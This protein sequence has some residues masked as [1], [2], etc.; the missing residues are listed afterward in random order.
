MKRSFRHTTDQDIVRLVL[1]RS[2]ASSIRATEVLDTSNIPSP[3]RTRQSWLTVSGSMIN[4]EEIK[5]RFVE[6]YPV[7]E[8]DADDRSEKKL[9]AL[10]GK[11]GGLPWQASDHDDE[12]VS[13]LVT[14]WLAAASDPLE[15]RILSFKE[16]SKEWDID[17]YIPPNDT[18]IIDALGA[19]Q[20]LQR[21]AVVPEMI[22]PTLEGSITF[23]FVRDTRYILL[24][25]F[26]EGTIVYL[27]RAGDEEPE[28]REITL[29]DIASLAQELSNG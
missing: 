28:V 23:E 5:Y 27:D 2:L 15:R 16:W 14:E 25:F 11:K 9:A 20:A 22:N 26:N 12:F 3:R 19:L 18:A 21:F 24:E 10:G 6:L 1:I 17:N 29:E 4:S 7:D 13:L 8:P